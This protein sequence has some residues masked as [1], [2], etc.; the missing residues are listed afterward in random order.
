[1]T[2]TTSTALALILAGG[3]AIADNHDTGE[4]ASDSAAAMENEQMA[5]ADTGMMDA[6]MS[7]ADL[8]RTRDMTGGPVYSLDAEMGMGEW[9]Q[10]EYDAVAT[11]WDQ[12]GEIED[13]VLTRGGELAGVVAEVGGFID[14]GDTH[15]FLRVDDMKL[16]PVDDVNYA[17]VVR[18]SEEEL[19]AMNS[20]D[21]GFWN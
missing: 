8:I 4:S 6:P 9:T 2:R 20:V 16:V 3:T 7:S 12:I 5:D 17:L 10:D 21:E 13:L 11:G 18:Q 15:V 14:I 19:E 1:M